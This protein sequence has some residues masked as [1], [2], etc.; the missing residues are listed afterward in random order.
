MEVELTKQVEKHNREGGKE[1]WT[2]TKKS[3]KE[4]KEKWTTSGTT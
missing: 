2:K 3:R 4:R 1:R